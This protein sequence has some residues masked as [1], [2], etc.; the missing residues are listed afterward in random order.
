MKGHNHEA[1]AVDFNVDEEGYH[2]HG[3]TGWQKQEVLIEQLA[4][5]G[6]SFACRVLALSSNS[7]LD[8]DIVAF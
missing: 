4:H 8:I 7:D 6:I 1:D 5:P 2:K 3:L